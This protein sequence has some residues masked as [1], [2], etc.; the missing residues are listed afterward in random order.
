M[1]GAHSHGCGLQ[2][3]APA[4]NHTPAPMHGTPRSNVSITMLLTRRPGCLTAEDAVRMLQ[5][6]HWA[7]SSP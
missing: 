2:A 1:M 5:A 6:H 7:V 4:T 3:E